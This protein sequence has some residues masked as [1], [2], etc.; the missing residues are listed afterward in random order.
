[1]KKRIVVLVSVFVMVALAAATAPAKKFPKGPKKGL[2]QLDFV[3]IGNEES[4]NGHD[5]D[6]WG[7][8]EP[9]TNG[10]FWGDIENGGINVSGCPG[11]SEDYPLPGQT[12]V[13]W[14]G[15]EPDSPFL[16]GRA[17]SLVLTPEKGAGK[18]INM[19][20]LDSQAVDGN[21]KLLDSFQVFVKN[22]HGH[23]ILVYVFDPGPPAAESLPEDRFCGNAKSPDT[24]EEW[25]VHSIWLPTN[26]IRPGK[27]VK[28]LIQ[29]TGS[30]WELFETYG[31]LAVDW[32]ELVGRGSKNLPDPLY[33]D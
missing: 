25:R 13:V 8:I 28:V 18:K 17:A 23:W 26:E 19:R 4:E 30:A 5:L 32:I 2:R 6:G 29:A 7:P 33:D 12:R 11:V 21:E 1:M 31:Q 24:A 20:V 3:D 9:T 16:E 14:G 10:G 15:E 22:K 27:P